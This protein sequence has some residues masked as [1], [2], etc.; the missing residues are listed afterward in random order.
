M[1]NSDRNCYVVSYPGRKGNNW[2]GLNAVHFSFV[3][4]IE[5]GA[6]HVL[7]NKQNVDEPD[8]YSSR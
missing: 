1:F 8:N 2:F 3:V 7:I 4:D 6:S 5:T